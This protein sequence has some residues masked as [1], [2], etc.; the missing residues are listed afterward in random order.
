VDD[1]RE[2]FDN[3]LGRMIGKLHHLMWEAGRHRLASAG[4]DLDMKQAILLA[5]LWYH[6]G[7]C[8]NEIT[9]KFGKHKAGITRSIDRLEEKALVVRV[10]DTSDRRLKMIYLT[11]KG[12]ELCTRIVPILNATEDTVLKGVSVKHATICKEVLR[13]AFLNLEAYRNQIDPA[14]V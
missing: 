14:A 1:L 6:E 12:K 5:N 13:Q 10:T 3:N 4:L 9:R 11:Q 2:G 8:Q 7:M